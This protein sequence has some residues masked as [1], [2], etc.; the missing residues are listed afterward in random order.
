M[1]NKPGFK[2]QIKIVSFVIITVL[3]VFFLYLLLSHHLGQYKQNIINSY[4]GWQRSILY[5]TVREAMQNTDE[6]F[7]AYIVDTITNRLSTNE[8]TYYIFYK[9]NIVIYENNNELTK[10]HS[11]R[12]IRQMYGEYSYYGG[13]NMEEILI[14]MEGKTDGSGYFIKDHKRGGEQVIWL[15]FNY[16]GS[17]YIFGS[18]S[19]EQYILGLFDYE[20]ER[21]NLYAVSYIYSFMLIF[22]CVTI[23]LDSFREYK[24]R[25]KHNNEN[26]LNERTIKRLK[27]TISDLESKF[28]RLSIYDFLTGAFNRRF[29]D[30]FYPKL[31]GRIF[32]PLSIALIDVNGLKLIN[33]TFGYKE[34][35]NVLSGVAKIIFE[36]CSKKDV[37]VRY[38][39]DEF[40]IIMINTPNKEAMEKLIAISKKAFKEFNGLAVDVAIGIGTRTKMEEDLNDI[41]QNAEKNLGIDKLTTEKS[42]QSGT[43]QMLRRILREKTAE[44]EEHCERIKKYASKLAAAIG[45][46][47]NKVKQLA[48]LAYLHDVGKIAIPD[49]I[50]N[51]KGVLSDEEY[52][53]MKNHT[54]IGYNIAMSS[55]SLKPI[56]KHILQHHERWDGSGYPKG[57]SG[58]NITI[59]AR[60]ISI[61]D[62]FDT[63]LSKRSYKERVSVPE[64]LNEIEACAGTQFDPELAKTFVKIM[65]E[66]ERQK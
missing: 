62:A 44:T 31:E 1:I 46:N 39:A 13:Y 26:I 18:A 60:I 30:I 6:N 19:Y 42:V 3:F 36:H 7:D 23:C 11:G 55:P 12:N 5:N 20:N 27:A 14:E 37:I 63:M 52:E 54:T 51:K 21:N 22:F 56:A 16:G 47:E 4:L 49:N 40:A 38:G 48:F 28:E 17:S 53:I 59:E 24:E 58:E 35:D 34:G 8:S 33:N 15:A 2:Y 10:K 25:I 61:A 29:F 57:I 66:E 32:L 50:I 64:A 9:D 45:M 41:L 65:K 43:I